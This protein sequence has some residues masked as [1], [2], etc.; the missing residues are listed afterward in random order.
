MDKDFRRSVVLSILILGVLFAGILMLNAG[1][2]KIG[3]FDILKALFLKSD[4]G[5]NMIVWDI[6][7]PRIIIGLLCGAGL[8]VSGCIL[9]SVTGNA[10]ADPSILGINSGAGIAILIFIVFFPELH[11]AGMIFMPVFAFAGG[12]SV[13]L[14][15]YIFAYRNGRLS[16]N[17][18]LLGG[19]A[20]SAGGTAI[21]LVMS[22]GLQGSNFQ[23][24]SRWLVGSV[25]GT[26]WYH[27]QSLAPY[28]IVLIIF[29]L[30][31][32]RK[33]D[34]LM[35]GDETATGLGVKV[36]REHRI[37][38]LTAVGLSAACISVCGGVGFVG[39]VSPHIAKR[40]LGTRHWTLVPGSM[41]IGM[42]IFMLSDAIGR[43]FLSTIEIPVGII[44]AI[45]AAPYFLFLLRR[46][47]Y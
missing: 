22:T 45:I 44:I 28:L 5:Y 3:Y 38:L 25:W 39:L 1:Y 29:V 37:L 43:S 46:K 33:M 17:Y 47:V 31:R 36:E 7:M 12:M 21:M 4:A 41:L 42:F 6:R 15:L 18:F 27:V 24:V 2:S 8:G 9:Q 34:V 26:N 14:F 20:A 19:I 11:I 16:S 10:L 32:S 40:I 13:A 30:M 23:M 35:L